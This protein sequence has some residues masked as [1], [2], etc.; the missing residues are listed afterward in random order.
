MSA[1]VAE[2]VVRTFGAA[3][4]VSD[5][6]LTVQRREVVGLVGA[7]GAGKTTLIRVLLGLLSPDRGAVRLAGGAP[8]RA[9]RRRVGYV[10]QSLGLWTDLT[11]REHLELSRDV[12]GR[13][14]AQI[15]DDG[16]ARVANRPVGTLPLGLRRRAAFAVALAHDPDVIILDEPT[17]GVDPLARSRL[18]ETIREVADAGAAILVSTHYLDEAARCDRVVLLA[19]GR[20]VA[21]GTV[22]ELTADRR[23]IEVSAPRW[24]EAWQR[25]EQGGLDVLPGARDLRVAGADEDEVRR[26]LAGLEVELSSVPA[27]LDEVFLQVATR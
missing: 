8:N 4:A 25:L 18:W 14:R 20:V 5:V 17:S 9:T 22:A 24:Q 23:T 26:L 19:G 7:N 1:I 15:G 2:N 12:Y 10:P 6:S 13:T 16:L 27:T 21:D 11:L 3:T